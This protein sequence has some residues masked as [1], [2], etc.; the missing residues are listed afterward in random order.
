MSW[1]PDGRWLY[2]GGFDH[3]VA[4]Y[5]A[6]SWGDPVQELTLD[7]G[8]ESVSWSPDGRWLCVGGN[9]EKAAIYSTNSWGDLVQEVA[10]GDTVFSVSWSPDG[11][12]LC[13]GVQGFHR[14]LSRYQNLPVQLID[15]ISWTLLYIQNT[16]L[17]N[18]QPHFCSV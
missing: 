2:V 14:S 17:L 13:V 1:S 12:W 11:R 16:T 3:K 7:R 8:V 9:D 4:I 18:L 10:R 6:D 5:S 15:M